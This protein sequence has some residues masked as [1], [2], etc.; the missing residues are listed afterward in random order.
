MTLSQL[1][2]RSLKRKTRGPLWEYIPSLNV[3]NVVTYRALSIGFSIYTFG[4]LAGIVWSYRTTA[5]LMDLRVK[6]V[7]AIVAWVLFA[8]LLQ[9]YVSGDY[10]ARRTIFLSAGAF[11]AILVAILG[12]HRV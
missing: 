2:D 1:Q 10:R 5:E 4:I 3:C 6:Q 8:M 12:I 7:G 9:S 11:V